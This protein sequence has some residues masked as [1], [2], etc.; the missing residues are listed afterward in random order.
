MPTLNRETVK[1]I[2][3]RPIISVPMDGIEGWDGVE[4]KL[5]AMDG[6][7]RAAVEAEWMESPTGKLPPFYKE[8]VLARC[9]VD[10]EGK[11]VFAS[12]TD[13]DVIV[14]TQA[15]LDAIARFSAAATTRLYNRAS[16]M[17]GL[18]AKAVETAAKN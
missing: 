16:V 2:C 17:N 3:D 13:A 8:R 6:R 15:D 11:L 4:V 5:R 7:L 12:S 14:V 10:D 18:D 9:I 1:T